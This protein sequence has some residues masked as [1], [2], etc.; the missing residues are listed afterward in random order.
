MWRG[1]K[2]AGGGSGGGEGRGKESKK[3]GGGE[4]GWEGGKVGGTVCHN[5]EN[6][7]PFKKALPTRQSRT[8]DFFYTGEE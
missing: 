7:I 6:P 5:N 2:L 1:E 8:R 3:G 4:K